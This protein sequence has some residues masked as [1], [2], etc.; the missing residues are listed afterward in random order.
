MNISDFNY[1][2][3]ILWFSCAVILFVAGIKTGGKHGRYFKVICFALPAFIAFG[4]S[5]I[6]EAQTGV[7]WRPWSLLFLKLT[8]VVI[9]AG[10]YYRYHRINKENT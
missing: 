2:E 1:I 5:D 8:C 10:C 9:I 4:I 3:S 7:W 6:I